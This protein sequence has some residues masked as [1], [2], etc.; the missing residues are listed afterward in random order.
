MLGQSNNVVLGDMIYSE[1]GHRA[2]SRWVMSYSVYFCH[3]N[4]KGNT[5]A[6]DTGSGVIIVGDI[7]NTVQGVIFYVLSLS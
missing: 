6:M 7:F 4:E 1:L 5:F 3:E 2:T